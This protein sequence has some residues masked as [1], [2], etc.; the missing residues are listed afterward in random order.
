MATKKHETVVGG[1]VTTTKGRLS[2]PHLLSKHT[3]GEYPS[4]KYETT[5][6]IP[7]STDISKLEKAVMDVAQK[8]FPG[9]ITKLSDLAHN[10]IGDGDEKDL[11]G[12]KGHWTIRAK[13]KYPPQIVGPDVQPLTLADPSEA[14]Y[15]GAYAKI[16]MK[17]LSFVQAGKP[18]VTWQL[19]NVQWLG[20]GDRFGGGGSSPS[21]D[22]EQEQD[23]SADVDFGQPNI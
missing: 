13:S 17:P 3:E 21:S 18:G 16:S 23:N 11:D 20:H 14:I 2:F 7:K 10:P 22:F 15:G 19:Q 4:N 5:L 9:K 8:A 12:Y 1:T 6:L